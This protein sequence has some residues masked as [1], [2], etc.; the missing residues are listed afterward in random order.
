MWDVLCAIYLQ[1]SSDIMLSLVANSK[2]RKVVEGVETVRI[3]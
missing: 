1:S 2:Y 3:R